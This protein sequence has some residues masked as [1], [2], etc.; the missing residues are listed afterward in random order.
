YY[1]HCGG[2]SSGAGV[3]GSIVGWSIDAAAS[4]WYLVPVSDEDAAE[5]IAAYDDSDEKRWNDAQDVIADAL[6]K[7]T[8]AEDILVGTDGLI[9]SADQ[10]SSPYSQNDLGSEDGGGLETLIDNDAST[11]W[12]SYYDGG[13][14]DDGT[15]YIQ[16]ELPEDEGELV[17]VFTRRSSNNDHILLWGVYGTNDANAGEAESDCSYIA[18][19]STP[20]GSSGETLTSDVFDATGY[21]YLRFYADE[22]T[23]YAD[24]S[25]GYFHLAEFQLYTVTVNPTSQMVE[26]GS[27]YTDLEAAVAAAQ[28]EGSANDG[29]SK[30]TYNTLM[31]A[32]EAFIAAFVDPTEL[33]T[34]LSNAEEAVASVVTGT[35]PGYW[36]A[37]DTS[38]NSTISNATAYDAAGKYTQTESDTYVTQ[39]NDGVDNL[40][41][42]AIGIQEGKWYEIRYASED[43][44]T[45]H[46]WST[47]NAVNES[48]NFDLRDTYLCV[49]D[50]V[51]EEGQDD[52]EVGSI[53]PLGT[54]ALEDVCVG[55]QLHFADKQ[56]DI[57]D[58]DG[59]KFRFVNVGDTAYMIQNKATGLFIRAAGETG[60]VSLSAHPTLFNVSAIGYGEN[61]I[62]GVTTDGENCNNLHAQLAYQVLVTWA[63]SDPGTNS[64]LYIEDTGEAVASD[65]EGTSFNIAVVPGTYNFFCFGTGVTAEEGTMYGVQ[66][67]SGTTITLKQIEGNKAEPGQPFVFVNGTYD[68][69]ETDAEVV[70]FSHDYTV[71]AEAQIVGE[72]VG[73]YYSEEIGAGKGVAS[74]DA[75]V[76][77]T[78]SSTETGDNSA[79]IST[80]FETGSE[81][82][83]VIDADGYFDS[84]EEAVAATTQAGNIYTIDGK[85]VGKG[86]L[87]KVKSLGKGIYILNG[88]KILVK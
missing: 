87:S 64:G 12:H 23:G 40:M 61:L 42:S 58:E 57:S 75:I 52:D 55:Q 74:D 37:E 44:M 9:E 71:A 32:Y 84:I 17:F 77:S 8:I 29:L 6:E 45:A 50:F 60:A 30:T 31:S 83:I 13:I 3:S 48:Y 82:T 78:S 79:Y 54:S 15:H 25:R 36:S 65:Y 69:T 70:N 2:H 62:S 10:L 28:A 51:T 35:N 67:V 34:A 24:G 11:Y 66:S 7:M 73:V 4:Q 39:L 16:V 53:E 68:E 18:Q 46:S 14:V 19:I 49:A 47:G 59:A 88:A 1:L 27:V 38:L 76:V 56:M 26:M 20:F 43:E 80:S 33:R 5:L 72:M 85:L 21:K 22:T 81:L 86:D 63:A 41:A